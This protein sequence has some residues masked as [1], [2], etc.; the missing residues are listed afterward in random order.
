MASGSSNDAASPRA[1]PGNQ[2]V[3]RALSIIELCA[4]TPRTSH[5]I[6]EILGIHRTTVTRLLAVL[7][8]A[9]FIRRRADGQYTAG[10]RLAAL[11]QAALDGYDLR[12]A[13]HPLLQDLSDRTGQTV[14]FAVATGSAVVYVDKIEPPSSIRL[15]TRVGAEVVEQ[16]AGVAKAILAYLP[17]DDL[18]ARLAGWQWTRY[19]PSTLMTPQ[20]YKQRLAETRA[21]GWAYDEGEYEELSHNIAAPVR[22]HT[23]AVIG[24]VSVTAIRTKVDR[25]ALRAMLPQLLET[26]S[27]MT[28]QLGGRRSVE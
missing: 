23:G 2:S 5:E 10:L 17:E 19:T 7:S 27:T 14:Q 20:A 15:D 28:E 4:A 12:R 22:D 8:D 11:G 25:A 26:T 16:T 21:Q 3:T 9:A 24:A 1:N 6:S 18:D 13:M